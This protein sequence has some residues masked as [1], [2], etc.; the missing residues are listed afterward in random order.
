MQAVAR[1]ALLLW[2]TTLVPAPASAQ[3]F[4]VLNDGKFGKAIVKRWQMPKDFIE[5]VEG[6]HDRDNMT[7]HTH[8][9]QIVS[10]A[11]LLV[12]K[13]DYSLIADEGSDLAESELAKLLGLDEAKI[14][15]ILEQTEKY[16]TG[17]KS[18]V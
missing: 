16:V 5:V 7:K 12:R 14:D 10:F 13:L 9:T 18:V 2:V 11:N 17:M 4:T 15:T 8:A 3:T 6:H 1:L